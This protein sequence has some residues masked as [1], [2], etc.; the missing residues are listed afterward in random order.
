MLS[1]S[2]S[3]TL[4]YER[5]VDDPDGGVQ[6]PGAHR[7]L[8]WWCILGN[9]WGGGGGGGGGG[10]AQRLQPVEEENEHPDDGDGGGNAG[11]HGQVKGRKEREDVDLLLGLADQDAHAIVQVALTEVHHVLP[12]GGDG[13]GRHGQVR[14]LERERKRRMT[15]RMKNHEE[16]WRRTENDEEWWR[17]M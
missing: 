1:T 6:R 9:G 5:S 17:T 11:P 12:L 4:L 8:A 7:R 16:R 13:D 3:P 2:G 15:A 10:G 14:S